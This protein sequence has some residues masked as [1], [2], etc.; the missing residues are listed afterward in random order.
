MKQMFEILVPLALIVVLLMCMM[1]NNSE[2]YFKVG[3]GCTEEHQEDGFIPGDWE[4]SAGNSNSKKQCKV[5][6][7]WADWSSF[8]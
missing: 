7:V 3:L 1:N 4:P 8:V 6:M 2:E 5:T